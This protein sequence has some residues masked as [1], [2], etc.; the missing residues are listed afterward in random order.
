MA[1]CFP[2]PFGD[3]T[4][5]VGAAFTQRVAAMSPSQALLVRL[6]VELPLIFIW[7]SVL[8]CVLRLITR[9]GSGFTTGFFKLY[10]AQSVVDILAYSSVNFVT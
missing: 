10:V 8:C 6:C 5:T 4:H 9:K 7:F 2:Q 1:A 3:S